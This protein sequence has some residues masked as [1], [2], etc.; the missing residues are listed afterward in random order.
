MK[1]KINFK[2]L[3]DDKRTLKI[4]YILGV[5]G[6]VMLLFSP[7]ASDENLK[8]AEAD[9][10]ENDYCEKLEER[11]EEI[12]PSI[13]GVG[14]VDVMI[15]AKNYGKLLLAE[16]ENSQN[17]Q[18]VI[19]NQKGGGEDTKIVEEKLPEIQGVIIAADGGKSDK[20]KKDVTDAVTAL[21]GVETHK[22]KVFER[23]DNYDF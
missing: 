14:N 19:L 20:V 6:I 9:L 1:M 23:N 2:Q 11:L 7:G 13:A 8:K 21:L 18:T 4:I 15:T 5:V 16:D 10:K 22:I 17:R 3:I 12:L